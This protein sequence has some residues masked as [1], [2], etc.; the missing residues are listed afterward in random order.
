MV[1]VM[2][3]QYYLLIEQRRVRDRRVEKT[4]SILPKMISEFKPSD[5]LY[6]KLGWPKTFEAQIIL[7]EASRRMSQREGFDIQ[8][9][10]RGATRPTFNWVKAQPCN[11]LGLQLFIHKPV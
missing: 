11:F 9:G 4:F 3:C 8:S 6:E 5:E 1:N 10:A 2:D 7:E